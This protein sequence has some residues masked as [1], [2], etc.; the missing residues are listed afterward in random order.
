MI[1]INIIIDMIIVSLWGV[2]VGEVGSGMWVGSD[3]LILNITGL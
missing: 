2:E 3:Q 1:S